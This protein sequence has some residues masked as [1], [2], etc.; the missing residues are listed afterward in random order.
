M[1]TDLGA[2]VSEDE[3]I[4]PAG[5][6]CRRNGIPFVLANDTTV[7]CDRANYKLFFS[8]EEQSPA[9]PVHAAPL[10]VMSM[11]NNSSLA[12]KWPLR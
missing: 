5:T 9:N 4:L 6:V 1:Q 7:K 11:T 10:P 12:S 8:H 2:Q 3:V